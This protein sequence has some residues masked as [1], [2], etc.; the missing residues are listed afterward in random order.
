M[1][2]RRIKGITL[3]ETVV[4]AGMS[5]IV[6][7]ASLA[8][9][10]Q[11]AGSW[12]K[13]QSNMTVQDQSR[14]TV[15]LISDELRESMSV[16]VDADGMGV[17]YR[18]PQLDGEGNYIT[19]VIWDGVTRRIYYSNGKIYM[20]PSG[21][22]RIICKDVIATDPALGGNPAYRTF[23]PAAGTITRAIDVKVITSTNSGI[24]NTNVISRKR[25]TVYL[26]NVPELVL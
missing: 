19:P 15:R 24:N 21:Q 5:T 23:I 22:E 8:C 26:R 11:G 1:K 3:V 18:K 9:F 4:A 25:E 10:L 12:A 6:L 16:F 13:G 14:R 20:G 7:F 2:N 17:S